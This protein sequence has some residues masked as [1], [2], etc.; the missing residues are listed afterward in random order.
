[1]KASGDGNFHLQRRHNSSKE[2]PADSFVGDAGFWAVESQFQHYIEATDSILESTG[3]VS[4]SGHSGRLDLNFLKNDGSKGTV[5]HKLET[6]F[7]QLKMQ[8]LQ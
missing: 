5:Q 8:S 7:D 2:T 4:P 3:Q 1:M 6:Q